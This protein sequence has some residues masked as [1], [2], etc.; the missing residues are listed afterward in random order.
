MLLIKL[1]NILNLLILLIGFLLLNITFSIQLAIC[2]SPLIHLFSRSTYERYCF[3]N[4]SNST[5]SDNKA[6][7]K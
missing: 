5:T 2:Q 6:H 3:G 4:E 7:L 1:S